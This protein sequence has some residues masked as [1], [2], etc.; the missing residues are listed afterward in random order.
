MRSSLWRLRGGP[1]PCAAGA[2][3]RADQRVVGD[4]F[5]MALERLMGLVLVALSIEMLLRGIKAFIKQV[6]GA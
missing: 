5:V 3:A 6:A 4:R 2:G 1:D